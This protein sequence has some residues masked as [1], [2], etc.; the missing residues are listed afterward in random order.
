MTFQTLL[1]HTRTEAC[2]VDAKA[3][4]KQ[5]GESVET[6]KQ[7]GADAQQALDAIQAQITA[8]GKNVSEY[9][10]EDVKKMS[11]Q[12]KEEQNAFAEAIQTSTEAQKKESMLAL[13]VATLKTGLIEAQHALTAMEAE[14]KL[15]QAL[16]EGYEAELHQAHLEA[17]LTQVSLFL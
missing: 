4:V 16:E 12:A 6:R 11:A 15:T 1:S 5:T 14:L 2:H 3:L 10:L 13:E 9:L 17:K 8:A 7:A